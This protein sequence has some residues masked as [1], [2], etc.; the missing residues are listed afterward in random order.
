ME[1]F[2]IHTER[3]ILTPLG[4]RFLRTAN[5]YALDREN[6]KYMSN[7]PNESPEETAEFLREAESEWA[8]EEP[9]YYEFAMLR[10]GRHIGAVSIYF[11]DGIGELGWIVN[12]RYWGNGFAR[13]AADGLIR[14]FAE[15]FGTTRFVAHCDA[16]NAASRRTMEKLG[17]VRTG[18]S[19]GRMNRS[20][21]NVS[22][23]Y[24]YEL[25]LHGP[26]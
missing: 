9:R 11:E 1:H 19:G 4:T 8:K 16:E 13:E 12:R 23:E 5:E 15:R 14:C 20:A 3:L 7:L 21:R 6:T 26:D 25:V 10:E 18:I 22:L 17:M 24:R 2:D